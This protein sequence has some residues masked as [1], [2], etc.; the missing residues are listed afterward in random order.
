MV[1]SLFFGRLVRLTCGNNKCNVNKWSLRYLVAGFVEVLNL[2]EDA[3]I[4]LLSL[5]RRLCSHEPSV[6]PSIS[7]RRMIATWGVKSCGFTICLPYFANILP[8]FY[9]SLVPLSQFVSL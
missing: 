3:G 2:D 4:E 9:H 5:D 7:K 8:Y 1:Q 6:A